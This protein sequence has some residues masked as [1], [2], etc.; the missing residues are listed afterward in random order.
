MCVC[1]SVALSVR[2]AKSGKS[3]QISIGARNVADLPD[4]VRTNF[5][6]AVAKFGPGTLRVARAV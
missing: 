3:G 4:P 1:V 2:I 5:W 6:T